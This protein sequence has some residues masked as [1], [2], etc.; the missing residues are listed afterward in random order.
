[1]KRQQTTPPEHLSAEAK[2]LWGELR[3][4]FCLDDSAGLMLLRSALEA[5]DLAQTARRLLAKE[6][7]VMK[8]RWG[9]AKPHPAASIERDARTQMHGALRLL[10]LAPEAIGEALAEDD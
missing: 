3:A 10:K 4:D 7:P 9:Q 6:G 1:M 2:R 8:D 5:F